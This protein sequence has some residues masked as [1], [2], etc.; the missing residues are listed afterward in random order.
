[1]TEYKCGHTTNGMIVLDDNLLSMSAYIQWAEEGNN[2]ETR[3]ECFDCYL[4]KLDSPNTAQQN[5]NN[6]KKKVID[7]KPTA[8]NEFYNEEFDI[9]CVKYCKIKHTKNLKNV[10]IVLDFDKNDNIVGLE[11]FDFIKA[12][13][14]EQKNIDKIF[15]SKERKEDKMDE[16][17]EERCIL[18]EQDLEDLQGA[19]NIAM[20][21]INKLRKKLGYEK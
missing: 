15:T 18:L 1:M 21:E 2:L 16:D 3:E 6:S 14:K 20:L 5:K 9:I 11:I 10:D 19:Y 13:D 12:M 17:T 8:Q 7:D 4:K